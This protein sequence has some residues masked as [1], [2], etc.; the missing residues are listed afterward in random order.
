MR[1]GVELGRV[2]LGN[3]GCE[4]CSDVRFELRAERS[5]VG[6]GGWKRSRVARGNANSKLGEHR[7]TWAR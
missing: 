5:E 3:T 1:S 7:R 2:E 4:Y 6:G